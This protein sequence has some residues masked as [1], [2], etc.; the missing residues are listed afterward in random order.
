MWWWQKNRNSGLMKKA[1]RRLPAFSVFEFQILPGTAIIVGAPI[2]LFPFLVGMGTAQY[3]AGYTTSDDAGAHRVFS[4]NDGA[5]EAACHGAANS[6]TDNLLST[7]PAVCH[8]LGIVPAI[9]LAGRVWTRLPGCQS[10]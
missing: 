5:K 7:R 6:A 10:P 3:A 1:G 9:A 8:I 4:A 2:D